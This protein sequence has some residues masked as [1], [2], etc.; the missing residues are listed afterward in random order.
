MKQAVF[1]AS[2][3]SEWQA[4]AQT[5]ELLEQGK[6]L[7][8]DDD[9]RVFGERYRRLV[10]QHALAID[11]Q[12]SVG[13]IDRLQHL[14]QRAHHQLYRSRSLLLTQILHFITAGFPQAIRRHARYFWVATFLFYGPALAMGAWAYFQ[15]D[16]IYSVM[17]PEAV[18]GME[19]AYDPE[20]ESPGRGP[21]R[22]SD[23]DLMM[24]GYYIMNNTGIGFRSYASGLV[25]GIGSVFIT[26]YNGLTIGAVAGHLTGLGF[27]DTFWSFVLGHGAFELTAI[28]ISAAGGLMLGVALLFPGARTRSAALSHAAKQTVPLIVGSALFFFIAAFIEA[29][30]SPSNTPVQV[31]YLVAAL[32]WSGVTLYFV[33]AG[34]GQDAD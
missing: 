1:E 23:T 17:S 8:P 2:Y 31:R 30:W 24:F 16:A 27:I 33:L 32:L 22:K 26:V 20:N 18:G 11:R 12:Y 4:L 3:Q 15:S 7:P 28:C 14:M 5:V 25:F 21:T 6:S 10:R 13:L 19:Y 9:L 34:R 29:F